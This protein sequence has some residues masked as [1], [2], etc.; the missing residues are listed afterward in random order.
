MKK[1]F[2]LIELL[3]VIAIIGTLV[4]LLLPAVQQ[5]RE[6]AARTRCA[7]NLRQLGLACHSFESARGG[8]PPLGNKP[9]DVS[10]VLQ[11]LPHVEQENLLAGYNDSLF[12]YDPAQ[13]EVV[14][15][16]ISIM[17]CP[18]NPVK[19][20]LIKGAVGAVNFEAAACDYFAL[21]G[22][23]SS[24]NWANPNNDLTGA[25]GNS[26]LRRLATIED[27]TSQTVMIGEIGGRP[28]AYLAGRVRNPNLNA[29]TGGSGAWAHNNTH[30]LM[31]Y[32]LDGLVKPGPCGVNCSN[33]N[34]L[35]SFHAEGVNALY[36]DGSVRLLRS[37]L[38]SNIAFA[39]STASGGELV[40]SSDY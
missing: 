16:R 34:A 8:L 23:N 25:M 28:F 5:S 15:K 7:N 19:G 4:A 3:V 29:S 30:A 35:F 10:W 11:I 12:W 14:T 37:R 1:G 40:T 39:L 6:A 38:D 18:S 13:K 21:R 32:T 9:T 26:F 33:Q 2:T 27:G 24:M 17:E 20:N 36:V 31:S 22:V